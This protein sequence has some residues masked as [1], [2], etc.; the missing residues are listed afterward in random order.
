[1]SDLITVPCHGPGYTC[2]AFS[3][4]GQYTF[5]GGQDCLVRIWKT[6]EGA[7]QEP[8]IATEAEEPVTSIAATDL[9]WISGSLDAEVRRYVGHGSSMSDV[10]TSSNALPTRSVAT[11]PEGKRLAVGSDNLKVIIV[12][13]EDSLQRTDLEGYQSGVRRATWHPSG[14]FLSTSNIDGTIT[15][16]NLIDSTPKIEATVSNI[17]PEVRDTQSSDFMHDCS[18]IWH[19]SGQHFYVAS[20]G[21]DIAII[22]K[23]TW[24]K[25]GSLSDRD[26]VGAVNALAISPDGAYLATACKSTIYLWSTQTRKIVSTRVANSNSVIVQLLFSPRE[27]LLAW[28][29]AGGAFNR[30]FKPLPETSKPTPAIPTNLFG[31]IDLDA[32]VGDDMDVDEAM[33]DGRDMDDFVVDDLGGGLRDEPEEKRSHGLV[34][35]MVSITK[36]QPP[37][38]P[39]STPLLGKKRYLAFNTIG[40][41]EA[42]EKEDGQIVAVEFFD[43]S[44]RKGFHFANN[45]NYDM[46]YLGE[47]GALFACPSSGAH[48]THVLYKPYGAPLA[49][50]TY[51]LK[52][53]GSKVLGI[54]AG[55]SSPKVKLRAEADR[56]LQGFGDIVVATNENDLTFLSGTGRERRIMGIGAEFVSMVAGP[57]WVLVVHRAGS[58]TIDGSQNLSYSLIM[59]EDFSV[60]QRD[61]LPIPKGH[62]LKWIG[63]TD[64]GVPAMYD[65]TGYL[66]ILTKFRIPH[67]ASWARVLD[68]NQMER[69]Q[70]KDESYWPVGVTENMFMCL[71]LKGRQDHPGF[72]RPLIQELPLKLPFRREEPKEEL[73]EREMLF[74]QQAMDALDEELTTDEIV[75]RERAMDKEFIQLIQTACKND[76]IPRALELTKLLHFLPSFDSAAKIAEFYHLAGLREKV[77]RLKADREE[78]D[79]RL[80]IAR[81]KRRRWLKP[82]LPPRQLPTM[83]DY[84]NSMK[85]DLLNDTRPPPHIERPGMARVTVPVIETTRYKAMPPPPVPSSQSQDW[86]DPSTSFSNSSPIGGEGKRKRTEDE[87]TF[88]TPA[89]DFGLTPKK[90]NPF[91]RKPVQDATRNPFARKPETN[92]VIQKSESFFDKVDAAE[93]DVPVSK[94]KKPAAKG[95]EKEKEKK[96]SGPKQA[97]LLAFKKARPQDK[98]PVGTSQDTQGDS[99]QVT[100]IPMS[101]GSNGETQLYD[102]IGF[103]SQLEDSQGS[104]D[105][106]TQPAE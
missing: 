34:K 104:N 52:R 27:N 35:E 7:Q 10:V 92:K 24:S 33:A 57:E 2:L 3:A 12:S 80:V 18:V 86:L 95:K 23:G 103:K 106:E 9:C 50:W 17:I 61:I 26:T 66:H 28:T 53:A 72:P 94:P 89:D 58:T 36:S 99:G 69:R 90:S 49:E 60:C 98:E 40:V 37:F 29:D 41:I 74:I 100:D 56:D 81:N 77:H 22:S 32:T 84:P 48:P 88:M 63:V 4:N 59:F 8:D 82:E 14:D 44:A 96:E 43:Q 21:H 25:T 31:D 42:T 67:H 101:N 1:M 54:A 6:N 76:N 105:E 55:G 13:L 47:R 20:R 64:Q 87:D 30:W 97:T 39:G 75:S 65:T 5:T 73:I 91:A 102:L 70:G 68:T 85:V 19:P 46:A 79:D 15:I 45:H 78:N 62:T 93:Q 16:W 83:G 38:Q 11:D 71:I 51:P